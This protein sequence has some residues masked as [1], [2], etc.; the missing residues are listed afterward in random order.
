M[1]TDELAALVKAALEAAVADGL[2]PSASVPE[3]TFE[4]PKRAE[5]GDWATNVALVAAGGSNPRAA[6]QALVERLP[7]S[8]LVEKVE[9]AGPG[10]LNFR[11]SSKWFCDVVRRAADPSSGFG[12]SSEGS[13]THINLEYIS[14]NPTGPMNV[15]SGRHAAVGDAIGGL[16]EATG[17][18][19]TREYLINDSGRQIDLFGQSVAAR[20]LQ[21]F[22]VEAELPADGYQGDYLIGVV[23]QIAEEVGDRLVKASPE[24]REQVLRHHALNRMIDSIKS[25]LERFGTRFDVWFSEE[26]M[27]NSGAVAAAI[28][29]LGEAGNLAETD[30]AVWFRS[31]E[32]GDD[33][34]RVI[35]RANGTTTYLIA[36]IA[37]LLDKAER[38]F[39]HLI[40]LW[41]PDHHGTIARMKAAAEALG[42]SRERVEIRLIQNVSLLRKGVAVKASK[43]TGDIIPLDELVDEV[44]RDAARYTFLTRS[45]DAPLEFDIELA[46]LEGPEN[47]VYYVQYAHSR[48]CSILR[49]AAEQGLSAISDGSLELLVHP[50]EEQLIRKLSA[51]EELV[52]NAAQARAPQRVTHYLEELASSFSAFYRD[53][54]VITEDRDLSQARLTLCL[55]TKG[56]LADALGLMRVSAPESM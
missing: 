56:V 55:A 11:L 20:Y 15:V 7:S 53:C 42:L 34:D 13:G 10:F 45:I 36:D 22:G 16:L 17:H 47:P 35:V 52:P 19:V 29:K 14:A 9:V 23:E 4:R 41:G 18:E 3:P 51:Y 30:G 49:K 48:I 32:F 46:K 2:L 50:S 25:S 28:E 1:V 39:D 37:Y 43:R 27:H 21:C 24:E 54:R 33:K 26:K 8:D 44:G 40:Y 38:G 5:H 31:S 12:R 6:A